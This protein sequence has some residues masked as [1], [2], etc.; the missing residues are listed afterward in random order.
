MTQNLDIIFL[1]TTTIKIA[2]F[3]T[4]TTQEWKKFG[5]KATHEQFEEG[6][7]QCFHLMYKS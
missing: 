2:T 4:T 1:F 5:F 6:I 7:D 3:T